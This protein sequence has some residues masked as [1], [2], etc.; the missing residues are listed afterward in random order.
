[1][2]D[3]ELQIGPSLINKLDCS[4]WYNFTN[5]HFFNLDLGVKVTVT[6]NLA[7]YP[8]HH[9]TYAPAKFEVATSNGLGDT[10][11]RKYIIWHCPVLQL[12][13]F[14]GGGGSNWLFPHL[15]TL[16]LGSRSH[17]NLAQYPLHQVIY[18]DAKFKVAK[19]NGVGG[20]T[21]TRNMTD[22]RM[23]DQL[24]CFIENIKM[25]GPFSKPHLRGGGGG[26]L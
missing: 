19:S 2:A 6:E 25:Q 15:L 9:V 14:W 12:F 18:A 21:I 24:W 22:S 7:Q 8:L 5:T 1:M 13:F 3:I 4:W 10:F 20:E 11:K 23:T 17:I 16:T 26:Q